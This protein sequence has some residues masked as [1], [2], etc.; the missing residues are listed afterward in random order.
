M[1]KYLIE[2]LICTIVAAVCTLISYVL[3]LEQSWQSAAN[4]FGV[5][6]LTMFIVGLYLKNKKK[7]I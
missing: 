6:F 3:G 2:M 5:A 7:N 1:K 4:T